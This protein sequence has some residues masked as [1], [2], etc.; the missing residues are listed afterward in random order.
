MKSII[1]LVSLIVLGGCGA[2]KEGVFLAVYTPSF[3]T[4]DAEVTWKDRMEATPFIWTDG[5][6]LHMIS[7][8]N[9]NS[10]AAEG[11]SL[12]IYDGKE[13]VSATSTLLAFSAAIVV[14]KRLV[15]VGVVNDEIALVESEDLLHWTDPRVIIPRVAG[16]KLY[17]SSIAARGDGS[18][19]LA[20][21]TCEAGTVCFNARFALSSDLYTWTDAGTIFKPSE[22]AACPTIRF[23]DGMYY[24]FWLRDIGHYATYV[25]RS[26]DLVT[27]EDSRE[28][29]LSSLGA[30]ESVNNSDM[31]LIEYNGEVVINFAVS[32][33]KT[34]SDIKLAHYRGTLEQ[35]VKEF[36]EKK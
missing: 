21:E 4:K 3:I 18:F 6:L 1:F 16:R 7:R 14:E 34:W 31:D 15:V 27:W 13:L 32:D 17:N 30:G 5:R 11:D 9:L 10:L 20:Y 36:F 24:V 29:V 28:V 2:K 8:R 19:V 26:A 35:F 33:Q 22:Y 25:S 23:I 12:E